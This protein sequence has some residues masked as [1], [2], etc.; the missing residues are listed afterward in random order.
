MG[1]S[2]KDSDFVNQSFHKKELSLKLQVEP[3]TPLALSRI[4]VHTLINIISRLLLEAVIS[5]VCCI[6]KSRTLEDFQHL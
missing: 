6:N 4:L 5:Q 1:T 3:I 2:W